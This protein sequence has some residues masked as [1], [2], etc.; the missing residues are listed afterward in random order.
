MYVW[1]VARLYLQGFTYLWLCKEFLLRICLTILQEM[2][3]SF[4]VRV[5]LEANTNFGKKTILPQK[6]FWRLTKCIFL[7]A[8]F[9]PHFVTEARQIEM[10]EKEVEFWKKF[11]CCGWWV[12][13]G[14][15]RI[16]LLEKDSKV[17]EP[18]SHV[19][20]GV[21]LQC[22]WRNRSTNHHPFARKKSF[23]CAKKVFVARLPSHGVHG[24][25]NS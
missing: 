8:T 9:R 22:W 25:Q 4:G 18:S 3:K 17:D 16:K 23:R 2:L 10:I 13:Q 5:Q 12:D 20:R 19:L 6:C 11:F 14:E 1:R 21:V 24:K 15:K 7:E